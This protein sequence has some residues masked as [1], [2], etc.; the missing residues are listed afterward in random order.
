MATI[1]ELRSQATV[2]KNE[3][4]TRQNTATR[5]GTNLLGI[6]DELEELGD[7]YVE[8]DSTTYNDF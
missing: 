1:D 6:I 4:G 8:L 7:E 5:V 3:T 2:I